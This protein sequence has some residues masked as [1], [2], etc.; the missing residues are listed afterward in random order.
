MTVARILRAGVQITIY[1]SPVCLLPYAAVPAA[2]NVRLTSSHICSLT[3]AA[4]PERPNGAG[5]GPAGL[6]PSKVQILA[7][8]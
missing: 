2:V 3:F 4:V 1:N 8:A 6:V 7:A 5:L